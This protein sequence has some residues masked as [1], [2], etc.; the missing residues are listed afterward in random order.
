MHAHRKMSANLP[1]GIR[2]NMC[3]GMKVIVREIPFS[4]TLLSVRCPHLLVLAR[5]RRFFCG[6][7]S[8]YF[9]DG[10]AG[11]RISSARAELE[12]ENGSHVLKLGAKRYHR[13]SSSLLL[14]CVVWCFPSACCV[15]LSVEG[16]WG[17]QAGVERLIVGVRSVLCCYGR[18]LPFSGALAGGES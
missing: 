18:R 13:L 2:K 8:V 17:E 4:H 15:F 1:V 7:A 5:L 16:G 12:Q 11:G 6:G 14:L 3:D 10:H 9:L